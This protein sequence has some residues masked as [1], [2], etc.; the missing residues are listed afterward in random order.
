MTRYLLR[1]HSCSLAHI[2]SSERPLRIAIKVGGQP[3]ARKARV[4]PLEPQ[5]L[6]PDAGNDDIGA[7]ADEQEVNFEEGSDLAAE[8][9]RLMEE[10]DEEEETEISGPGFI[11]SF[12]GFGAIN[13]D[14]ADFKQ[15]KKEDKHEK[16]DSDDE[17]MFMKE[18]Y[19][20]TNIPDSPNTK[21]DKTKKEGKKGGKK[22]KKDKEK[23]DN[24]TTK[25][26]SVEEKYAELVKVRKDL[27]EQL[28]K[29]HP[30]TKFYAMQL[31][32]VVSLLLN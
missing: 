13:N 1:W 28:E 21:K 16:C 19:T 20:K 22:E 15:M 11:L 5:P 24:I 4:E 31:K 12:D 30:I 10:Y 7:G 6:M 14:E 3:K 29:T 32:N 8:L 25:T 2:D 17:E 23:E 26:K 18:N 9:A 27:M